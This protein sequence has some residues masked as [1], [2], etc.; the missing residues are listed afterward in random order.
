MKRILS[1]ATA[2]LIGATAAEAQD[3]H[4][5]VFNVHASDLADPTA[6]RAKVAKAI[7]QGCGT[8]AGTDYI[9][10]R[11]VGRCR[12]EAKISSDRQIADAMKKRGA[13]HLAVAR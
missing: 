3:V 11:A 6:L 12:K 13:T 1:I 4:M 7:D 8:Y 2:M 9:E 10:W 5:F